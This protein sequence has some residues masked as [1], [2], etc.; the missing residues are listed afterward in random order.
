M[1][2]TVMVGVTARPVLTRR[3]RMA[4][5]NEYLGPA[6]IGLPAVGRHDRVRVPDGRSGEVIGYYRDDVEHMLV[7]FDTGGDAGT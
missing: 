5:L 4:Q 6:L 1:R 7:L 2:R 3:S